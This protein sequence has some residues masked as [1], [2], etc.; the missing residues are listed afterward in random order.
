MVNL[1]AYY[2]EETASFLQVSCKFLTKKDGKINMKN[3]LYFQFTKDYVTSIW[4]C[5]SRTLILQK[6]LC[7]LFH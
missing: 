5:L 6:N 4:D 2:E 1:F 7:Y 3:E